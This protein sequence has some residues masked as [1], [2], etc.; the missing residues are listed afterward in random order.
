MFNV[1]IRLTP[2]LDAQTY[3]GRDGA[4]RLSIP[5]DG[6]F[7]RRARGECLTTMS[8]MIRRFRLNASHSPV[9]TPLDE[10]EGGKGETYDARED[11]QPSRGLFTHSSTVH[12]RVQH[13]ELEHPA[14]KRY[15]PCLSRLVPARCPERGSTAA[16]PSAEDL[17]PKQ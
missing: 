10:F 11:S 8:K 1:E 2:S 7:A 12:H 17:D 6:G 4:S 5:D 13:E 9:R 15:R 3:S 16:E 14:P